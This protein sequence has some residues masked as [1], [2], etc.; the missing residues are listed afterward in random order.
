MTLTYD[1]ASRTVR[2]PGGDVVDLSSRVPLAGIVQ[3]L[4]EKRL[5]APGQPLDT[6]AL[7]AAGWPGE[8]VRADAAT[9]RVKVALSTLRKLGLRD[10]IL[11]RGDGHVIDPNVPLVVRGENAE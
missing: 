7:L 5:S 2:P 11:H 6:A 9:N 4:V 10:V 8:K 3:A 1:R